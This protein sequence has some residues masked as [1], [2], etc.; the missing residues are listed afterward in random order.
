VRT[1]VHQSAPLPEIALS[2]SGSRFG[3]RTGEF[4]ANHRGGEAMLVK[5]TPEERLT[6]VRAAQTMGLNVAGMDILGSNQLV[7]EVNSSPGLGGHRALLGQCRHFLDLHL[8]H[9]LRILAVSH[10][11][12]HTDH[13]ELFL[14]WR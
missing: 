7:L 1:E 6:A 11:T 2:V 9:A 3:T 10:R 8:T 12:Q 4:R 13:E 5:I 14:L